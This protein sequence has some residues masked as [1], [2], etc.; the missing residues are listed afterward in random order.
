MCIKEFTFI[1]LTLTNA[2][3]KTYKTTRCRCGQMLLNGT[4]YMDEYDY[5]FRGC[6][7]DFTCETETDGMRGKVDNENCVKQYKKNVSLFRC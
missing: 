7:E 2:T 1:K 3:D 6:R 4:R 5:Y